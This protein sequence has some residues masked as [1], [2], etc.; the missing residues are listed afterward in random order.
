MV[1]KIFAC[2]IGGAIFAILGS[3]VYGIATIDVSAAATEQGNAGVV[4]GVLWVLAAVGC[5]VAKSGGKAWRYMMLACC[6]ASFALPLASFIFSGAA[7]AEASDAGA[8]SAT[9]AAIGG[10]ILTAISGFVGFFLGIIFLIIGLL[11]GRDP[12]VVVVQADPP[13]QS[14]P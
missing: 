14:D 5:F 8:A 3:M 7:V 4:M 2:L 9:G 6:L 1:G 11:V 10:G 12:Q 13:P